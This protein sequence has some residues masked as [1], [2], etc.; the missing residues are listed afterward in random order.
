MKYEVIRNFCRRFPAPG[1]FHTLQSTCKFR[2][3]IRDQNPP[4]PDPSCAIFI[5][6]T[7]TF[8]SNSILYGSTSF[9]A[10]GEFQ[11][12]NNLPKLGLPAGHMLKGD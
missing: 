2:V 4:E 9:V 7:S 11:S 5:D 12:S 1:K 3:S 6:S 10:V 8:F